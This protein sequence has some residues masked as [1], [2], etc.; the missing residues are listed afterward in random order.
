MNTLINW[1]K[2]LRFEITWTVAAGLAFF[3]VLPWV[4]F[5]LY[6]SG[7]TSTGIVA[8]DYIADL[9]Y[10]L[11]RVAAVLLIV[12]GVF[13]WFFP[14]L[15]NHVDPDTPSEF[16][17]TSD[18]NKMTPTSRNTLAVVTIIGLLISVTLLLVFP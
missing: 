1:I 10:R 7:A 2:S 14:T 9:G 18:W 11:F 12:W 4:I 17:F 16:S 3:L 13:R 8:A 15:E 6:G 5:G